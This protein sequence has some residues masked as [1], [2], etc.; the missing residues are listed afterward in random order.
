M[1]AEYALTSHL[2]LQPSALDL[3]GPAR[4]E[5]LPDR[6]R[7]L[8]P[9]VPHPPSAS[10]LPVWRTTQ[11]SSRSASTP[12]W[13]SRL[14]KG[15]PCYCWQSDAQSGPSTGRCDPSSGRSFWLTSGCSRRTA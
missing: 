15:L 13:T 5:L 2:S 10:L 7:H 4:D 8:H 6:R 12:S 1:V 14:T 9:H 3:R 11:A